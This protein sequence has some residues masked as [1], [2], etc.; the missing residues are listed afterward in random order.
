MRVGSSTGCTYKLSSGSSPI[1]TT[2]ARDS[3]N[4]LF[5]IPILDFASGSNGS[6]AVAAVELQAAPAARF[7]LRDSFTIDRFVEDS[8]VFCTIFDDLGGVLVK[9]ERETLQNSAFVSWQQIYI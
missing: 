1:I 2:A 8:C 9:T 3:D 6:T 7:L 5:T 4:F